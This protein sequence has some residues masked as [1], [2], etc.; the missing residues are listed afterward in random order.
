MDHCEC[1]NWVRLGGLATNHHPDCP[2]VD[3]SLVDVWKVS[4]GRDYYFTRNETD[5]KTEAENGE[6]LLVTPEKMHLEIYES[7]P[8]FEGF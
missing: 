8:E 4:D 5:A 2:H 3:D 1:L 7:L 6:G